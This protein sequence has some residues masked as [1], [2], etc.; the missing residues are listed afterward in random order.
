MMIV[1]QGIL[2]KVWTNWL[3]KKF[4]DPYI[5]RSNST[6]Y[7]RV[8][9]RSHIAQEFEMWLWAEG[10]AV[11]RANKKCTLEFFDEADALAFVLRNS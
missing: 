11:R 7:S 2:N 9:R 6:D 5:V 3:R 10:A 8:A 4:T 1:D